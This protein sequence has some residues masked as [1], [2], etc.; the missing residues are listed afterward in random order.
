MPWAKGVMLKDEMPLLPSLLDRLSDDSHIQHGITACQDE[1]ERLSRKLQEAGS[2]ASDKLRL[3]Y[4]KDIG[5]QQVHINYL[6]GFV[7][8]VEDVRE[9]VRRDLGWL[10]NSRSFYRQTGEGF[11]AQITMLDEERYPYVAES[12]LNYGLPDWTGRTVSGVQHT[13]LERMLKKVL[14]T[15]EPRIIPETLDCTLLSEDELPGDSSLVFEINGM[16]WAEPAPV[17][18]QIRTELDLENGGITIVE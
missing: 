5:K 6:K 18:L 12:V 9:S 13:Q 17:H 14:L 4:E 8:S 2:G 11:D 3:K 16:L 1:I 15:Y 7:G 10:M